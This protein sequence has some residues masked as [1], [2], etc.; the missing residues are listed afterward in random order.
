MLAERGQHPFDS[1]VYFFEVMWDGVR[2]LAYFEDGAVRLQDRY[3]RDVTA[4]YPELQELAHQVDDATVLDGEIVV[5][6]GEGRPDFARLRE[7]AAAR[8]AE[9]ALALAAVAPVTYQ[10]F[11]VL[12]HDGRSTMTQ[13][14]WKRRRLLHWARPGGALAV[15]G[16]LANEGVA[17]FD[18]A[19][20][21]GLE[22]IMAKRR[23]SLYVPGRRSAAWLKLKVHE[24]QEFVIGGFTYGGRAPGARRRREPFASLLLGL[25]DGRGRLR[26]VGEVSGGFDAASARQTA[27]ALDPLVSGECPFGDEPPFQ[28]LVFWCRPELVATVRFGAWTDEGTLQFPLFEG[29]RPDVPAASCRLKTPVAA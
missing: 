3:R 15:P 28:R 23:D 8:D 29:L 14:L 10:A 21:H 1:S 6:D 16:V 27:A 12:Y 26:Y 2:T 25:Y 17:L 20:Q 11:D 5:L 19:R 24:R 13:P 7:R 9:E 18:A 4:L 22:G